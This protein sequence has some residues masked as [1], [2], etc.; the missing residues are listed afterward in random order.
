MALVDRSVAPMAARPPEDLTPPLTS[1]HEFPA[2]PAVERATLKDP[3]VNEIDLVVS[4]PAVDTVST[5]P[6]AQMRKVV[7]P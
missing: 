5:S 1:N 2:D 7:S 3:L 6:P 4:R